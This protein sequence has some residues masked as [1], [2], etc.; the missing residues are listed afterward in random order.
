[1]T[2]KELAQAL[3]ISAAMVSK[4]KDR[5]MPTESVDAARRWR[6]VYLQPGRVKG[7]RADTIGSIGSIGTGA[8]SAAAPAA[9][10]QARADAPSYLASKA[11][12]E[13][14]E[15]QL[16]ELRL[17]EVQGD[18]VRVAAVRAAMGGRL[19]TLRDSLL[20]IPPRVV[21]ILAA[22]TDP[23]AIHALLQREISASLSLA[24]GMA[25]E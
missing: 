22:E 5:G 21:P 20:Q 23:A 1:M 3:G 8:T 14:A 19:A 12:R 6:D 15:A 10:A 17:R 11:R 9:A 18:L 16:A 13:E 25:N 4:L 7:I 2:G 24:A